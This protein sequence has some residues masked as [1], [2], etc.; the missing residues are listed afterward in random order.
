ML[1]A[2]SSLCKPLGEIAV[3]EIWIKLHLT[4]VSLVQSV[5]YLPLIFVS[6]FYNRHFYLYLASSEPDFLLYYLYL[7][8]S[9]SDFYSI[10]CI[11][12]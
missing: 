3:D 5:N 9:E 11:Y 4:K 6:V 12:T 2:G 1:D 8:S 7:A 10:I